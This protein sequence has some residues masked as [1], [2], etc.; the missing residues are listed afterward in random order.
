MSIREN[1][2]STGH[3]REGGGVD[4]EEWSSF[5]IID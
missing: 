3:F 5:L 2:L 4:E 1:I